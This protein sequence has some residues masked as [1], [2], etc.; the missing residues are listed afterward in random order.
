MEYTI[1]FKSEKS[2]YIK[3]AFFRKVGDFNKLVVVATKEKITTDELVEVANFLINFEIAKDDFNEY[4]I[5]VTDK[6]M[7]LYNNNKTTNKK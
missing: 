5:Y 1:L 4:K 7:Q 6:Q 3:L 2:D